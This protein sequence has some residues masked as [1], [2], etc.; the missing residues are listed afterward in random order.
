[1]KSPKK[2]LTKRNLF[3]FIQFCI[4]FF[5]VS[6]PFW[7][8]TEVFQIYHPLWVIVPG[9]VF[10]TL[11]SLAFGTLFNLNERVLKVAKVVVGYW[12]AGGFI[13]FF[14]LLILSGLNFFA[15]FPPTW[16]AGSGLGIASLLIV[17]AYHHAS[18]IFV[19][20]ISLSSKKVTRPYSF[21][22]LSDIH[23]GSNGKHEVERILKH[24]EGL[25]YDFV[26]ITGDL[27]DEDYATYEALEPLANITVPTY[28]ITGNHEYYLRNKSF[29][30]FIH[31][32]DIYDVNDKKT[33]FEEIDIYGIDE[34]SDAEIVLKKLGVD[35]SRYALGLMHEPHTREMKKSEKLG[36][37]LMLSGHTHNGQIFP[38]TLMVKAKYRFLKGLYQLGNMAI[39]VSQGTSTWGPKMRLG[40]RNEITLINVHPEN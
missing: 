19:H 14:T 10:V 3:F 36:I 11:F 1:M 40:T 21:I 16:I 12:L 31:K 32:T 24:M 25:N 20:S 8:T 26:V 9:A 30:D 28:Y 34:L 23:I 37:D 6:F 39:H 18:H 4:L 13:L 22:Q 17:Y 5:G 15:G 29:K 27:I 38:F 35:T 2:I 7:Q 33:S